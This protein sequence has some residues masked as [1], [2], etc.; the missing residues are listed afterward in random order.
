[1][2]ID[3]NVLLDAI[4][5]TLPNNGDV[6]ENAITINEI[7]TMTGISEDNARKMMRGYVIDGT[8]G[9]TKAWRLSILGGYRTRVPAYY[10]KGQ[11][12]EQDL[13]LGTGQDVSS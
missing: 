5:K 8:V 12:N 9:I 11:R 10:Y 7:M 13:G 3:N 2:Q 1:M 4:R 6:S